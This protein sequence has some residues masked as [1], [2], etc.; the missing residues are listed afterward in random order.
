MADDVCIFVGMRAKYITDQHA[1]YLRKTY[2]QLG[3]NGIRII[4]PLDDSHTTV[5]RWSRSELD[6]WCIDWDLVEVS[7]NLNGELLL[8]IN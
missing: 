8:R 3:C 1:D 5:K 6:C 4:E 7:K 2:L